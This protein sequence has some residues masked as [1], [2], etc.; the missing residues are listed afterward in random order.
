MEILK[1]MRESLLTDLKLGIIAGGQLS[2]ML[3]QEATK[4]D[5]KT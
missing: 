2:K 5:I 3:I 1:I 4:W